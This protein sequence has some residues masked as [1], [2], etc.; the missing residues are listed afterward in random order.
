V[1]KRDRCASHIANDKEKNMEFIREYALLVAFTTPV[2]VIAV[3]QVQLFLAGD[4]GTLLFPT[5]SL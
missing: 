2:L 3:L 4:R 5:G 1:F